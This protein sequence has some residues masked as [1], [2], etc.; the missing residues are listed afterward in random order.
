MSRKYS[1]NDILK[2]IYGE[3]E[4]RENDEFLDALC[5][6]EEL[7]AAFEELQAGQQMLT[8]VELAPSKSSEGRIMHSAKAE[9]RRQRHRPVT[10]VVVGRIKRLNFQHFGSVFMEFFTCLT[11]GLAMHL[12]QNNTAQAAWG[13]SQDALKF[14]NRALDSRLDFAKDRLNAIIDNRAQAPAHLHHDT[15]QLVNTDPTVREQSVVLLNIK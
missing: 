2:F 4:P 14:D 11:I 15:Y 10:Q 7:F 6:D 8:P 9:Q 1:K 12:Y 3:M 13:F 5:T